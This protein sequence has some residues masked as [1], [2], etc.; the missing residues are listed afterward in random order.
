MSQS[1]TAVNLEWTPAWQ[2]GAQKSGGGQREG[3]WEGSRGN[4][5]DV[6]LHHVGSG[7]SSVSSDRPLLRSHTSQPGC[8]TCARSHSRLHRG[9]LHGV[10]Q[11]ASRGVPCPW[12]RGLAPAPCAPSHPDL[13]SRALS[14]APSG[15][16]SKSRFFRA[17]F[18][19]RLDRRDSVSFIFVVFLSSSCL[20][21]IFLSALH[22]E[23]TN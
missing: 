15:S 13:A 16:E 8:P 9:S 23:N 17:R 21:H 22:N 1:E 10:R 7:V 11:T 4:H 20:T 18:S 14:L 2:T 6:Y 19:L 5:L 12:A 3:C